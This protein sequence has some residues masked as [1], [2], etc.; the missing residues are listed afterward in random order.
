[1]AWGIAS[2]RLM[3][4][5]K[6]FNRTRTRLALWYAG[7][8]GLILSLSGFGVYE[9]IAHAHQVAVDRE[10]ESVAGTLHDSIELKLNQPGRL[11]PVIEELLP[12]LCLAGGNCMKEQLSPHRHILSAAN[13]GNYY[14][15]FFDRS[16]ELIAIASVDLQGLAQG[17]N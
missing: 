16:G 11:E 9:A 1:M 10:L 5:N 13:Q 12:N 14:V 17:L 3:N 15:R 2:I 7:V 6:L 4:Q 8:M